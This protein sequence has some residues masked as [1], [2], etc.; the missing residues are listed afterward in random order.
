MAKKIPFV[1]I[2]ILLIF[3]VAAC[4]RTQNAELDSMQ[5]PVTGNESA[6][7]P[8]EMPQ[9]DVKEAEEMDMIDE[10]EQG[11]M[12][13]EAVVEQ[14]A[15]EDMQDDMEMKEE[16]RPMPV[17][18]VF[19]GQTILIDVQSVT[20]CRSGGS[21]VEG[22]PI[23][24]GTGCD[25]WPEN[26][27]ERPFDNSMVEYDPNLDIVGQELGYDDEFFYAR[28]SL[29]QDEV[30]NPDLRHTYGIELDLDVDEDGDLLIYVVNPQQLGSGEWRAEGVYILHDADDDV[31]GVVAV[32]ADGQPYEGTGYEAL[33]Y[34]SGYGEDADAAF[35][36]LASG[37]EHAVEI[38]FKRYLVDEPES[39]LWW[40]WA[41]EGE[42][43]PGS[44]DYVDV[45]AADEKYQVDNTCRWV[46]GAP[47]NANLT[48]SCPIW[49]APPTPG[50]GPDAP[51]P[52]RQPGSPNNP[53]VII[54]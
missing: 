17:H 30:I 5:I 16:E 42:M 32:M 45:F 26:T 36:R 38:A 8:D 11:S 37:K 13:E 19:P 14:P 23:I 39:F 4:T 27:I 7:Q 1:P 21:R 22:E 51:P 6:A 9:E 10:T 53:P 35:A 50:P 24:V 18:S 34:E 3:I 47:P 54:N 29:H 48:N 12:D 2:L 41:V 25:I 31:G 43:L 33:V 20:D 15:K 28:I 49:T 52:P 40:M 44:F 46:F